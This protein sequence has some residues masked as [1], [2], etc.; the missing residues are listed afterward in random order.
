[1]AHKKHHK[2]ILL[3]MQ[4]IPVLRKSNRTTRR[5]IKMCNVLL[6]FDLLCKEVIGIQRQ[7]HAC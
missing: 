4:K 7:S 3:N 5:P 6:R 2:H 1:M